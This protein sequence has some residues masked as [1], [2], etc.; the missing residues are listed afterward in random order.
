MVTNEGREAMLLVAEWIYQKTKEHVQTLVGPGKSYKGN[1]SRYKRWV[2]A[3]RAKGAL[4]PPPGPLY[5]TF[6]NIKYYFLHEVAT[7]TIGINTARHM[8]TPCSTLPTR[9]NTCTPPSRW[10]NTPL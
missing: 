8:M 5:P 1:W 6:E 7:W 9:S 2:D 4:D 3:E 10:I